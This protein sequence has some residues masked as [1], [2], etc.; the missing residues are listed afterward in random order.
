MLIS[1]YYGS[2]LTFSNSQAPSVADILRADTFTHSRFYTQTLLHTKA[3]THRP[4]CTRTLLH[5]DAFT[6]RRFYAQTQTPLHTGAECTEQ[7]STMLLPIA[8]YISFCN[9]N[10]H[11]NC[12]KSSVPSCRGGPTLISFYYGILLAFSNF[13]APSVADILHADTFTHSRFY[14][15]T[16]LHTKAFTRRP[17]VYTNTFTHRCVYTHTLLCTDSFTHT[18]FYTQA[19]SAQK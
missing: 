2:L 18:C 14:T 4:S 5:A 19:P 17:S 10:S 6:H 1:F 15:Q 12:Q 9:G 16:L 13:Q 11:T 3:F 7:L 8:C